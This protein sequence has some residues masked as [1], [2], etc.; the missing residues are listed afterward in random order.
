MKRALVAGLAVLLAGASARAGTFDEARAVAFVE[1]CRVEEGARPHLRGLY[2]VALLHDAAGRDF[3]LSARQEELA[4]LQN[5]DGGFG[6]WKGD[7]STVSATFW[8]V[9]LLG[10]T[11]KG[12]ARPQACEAYLCTR[13]DALARK[14]GRV[15]ALATQR[16]IFRGLMALAA[17]EAKVP[18]LDRYLH[19]LTGEGQAQGTYQFLRV[20]QAFGRPVADRTKRLERLRT[21]ATDLLFRKYS[22][23]PR[24][25]DQYYIVEAAKMLG[26]ELDYAPDVRKGLDWVRNGPRGSKSP[27]HAEWAWRVWRLGHVMEMETGWVGGWLD[28]AWPPP[29]PTAGLYAPMPTLDGDQRA[30][31]AARR[32]LE[33][34]GQYK[35]VKSLTEGLEEKRKEGGFYEF[36]PP[37]GRESE[38][39]KRKKRIEET[40][41]ALVRYH[42][43]SAQPPEPDGVAEWLRRHVRDHL[44][45][46]SDGDLLTV[47]KCF[48][49]LGRAPPNGTLAAAI[50]ER[51]AGDPALLAYGLALLGKKPKFDASS[52]E[53]LEAMLGRAA[54]GGAMS[55]SVW[56]SWV[57]A[58]H[59]AGRRPACADRLLARLGAMQNGD[60]G[61]G[62]PQSPHSNLFDTVAAI[63]AARLLRRPE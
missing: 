30:S 4:G 7:R 34:A 9:A 22:S 10:R 6:L 45:E 28:E 2:Y 48:E 60:G 1:R 52:L 39:D 54:D 3:D 44:D 38:R 47:A 59:A 12:V 19:A 61:V 42:L 55:V 17:L 57:E 8:A 29:E 31:M 18:H 25:E 53:P 15:N 33:P 16:E 32:L 46:M 51:F 35:P 41:Q 56:A 23:W 62:H 36:S 49:L 21:L 58:L 20:S 11:E 13:L 5:A 50:E 26:G 24:R 37:R 14:A 63:H 43:A 27:D 40:W